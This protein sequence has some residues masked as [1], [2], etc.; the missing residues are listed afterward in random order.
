MKIYS[1]PECQPAILFAI[2][3]Y[4]HG[5]K[6]ESVPKDEIVKEL[7]PLRSEKISRSEKE[8]KANIDLGVELKLLEENKG[9]AVKLAKALRDSG[10][11][12][13]SKKVFLK[14]LRTC[15]LKKPVGGFIFAE[16]EPRKNTADFVPTLAWWLGRS[17]NNGFPA[18][19]SIGNRNLLEEDGVEPKLVQNEEQWAC[20]RRWAVSLGFMIPMRKGNRELLFPSLTIPFS[21]F[22]DDFDKGSMNMKGTDGLL[23]KLR[24][25]FPM[26]DNTTLA[27]EV[28]NYI[29]HGEFVREVEGADLGPAVF[30]ALKNL[31]CQK[32]IKITSAADEAAENAIFQSNIVGLQRIRKVEIK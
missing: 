31:D 12:R 11:L 15:V 29:A 32:K 9:G 7:R 28:D 23:K 22:F 20:F 26:I 1:R 2:C 27:N 8:V 16:R 19:R 10:D 6:G 5:R 13:I 14:E 30:E 24:T 18:N 3:R 21:D 4:L 17:P 25:A